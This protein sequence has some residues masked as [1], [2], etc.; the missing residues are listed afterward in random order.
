MF[1]ESA[2]R[3]NCPHSISP[4]SERQ[5]SELFNCCGLRTTGI[6]FSRFS[7][8]NLTSLN[9][10][11]LSRARSVKIGVMVRDCRKANAID[12][13]KK[14]AEADL[15]SIHPDAQPRADKVVSDPDRAGFVCMRIAEKRV[16]RHTQSPNDAALLKYGVHVERLSSSPT[17]ASV[18][19]WV[20]R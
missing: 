20:T 5:R 14:A 10:S 9:T 13:R 8:P 18:S 3:S 6:T 7:I 19:C 4:R 16:V 11:T 2:L 17:W 1:L 15:I 12:P